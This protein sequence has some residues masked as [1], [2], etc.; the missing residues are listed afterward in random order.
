MAE[1]NP[2]AKLDR[3]EEHFAELE[4]L[5]GDFTRPERGGTHSFVQETWHMADG[6]WEVI[7]CEAVVRS[8]P[9]RLGLIAGDAMHNVRAALDHLAARLVLANGCEITRRTQFPIYDHEPGARE[10]RRINGNLEG[11]DEDD[12]QLIREMQ[13]YL[14]MGSWRS[15]RLLDLAHMDNH[16]KHRVVHPAYGKSDAITIYPDPPDLA[17]K[18]PVDYL[19]FVAVVPGTPLLRWRTDGPLRGVRADFRFTIGF[20]EAPREPL[21]LRQ[22]RRIR[23]EV[24]NIV[25]SFSRA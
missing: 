2:L 19:Q 4:G 10:A 7:K 20:G 3:A 8:P 14:E 12:A 6:D 25:E 22:L 17:G 5:I 11:M 21:T 18:P 15:K 23:D 9:P 24:R 16:D 1:P 13:P